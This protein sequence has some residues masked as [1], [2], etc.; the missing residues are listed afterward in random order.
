MSTRELSVAGLAMPFADVRLWLVDLDGAAAQAADAWLSPS[1]RQRAARF[2]FPRD[3]QRYR[4]AHVA[5]RQLLWQ[6]AGLAPG[7]EFEL[8]AHGK[9]RLGGPAASGFSLSH[10][11]EQA[12]IAIARDDC[13]GVDIE[14]L[15]PVGDALAL[16]EQNFSGAELEALRRVPGGDRLR[17]FLTGWTRKEACLKAVGWGLSIAPASVDVGLEP[18]PRES[19]LAVGRNSTG[20][21]VQTVATGENALA[22]IARVSRR[23]NEHADFTQA[24]GSRP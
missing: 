24:G 4:A 15:R 10:S 16:A 22:A 21:C 12:L 18:G 1:E 20:V 2:V 8:G 14:V 13:I 3:A 5:L 9:P 6:H 11:G 23:A 7:A 19:T 17:A